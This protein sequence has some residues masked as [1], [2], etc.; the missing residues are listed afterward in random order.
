MN[1]KNKILVIEDQEDIRSTLVEMLTEE[2][3]YM[4][5]A[6]NGRLGINI[7]ISE[8]PD[9]IICD[10]AMPE[11]NGYEVLNYVRDNSFTEAIP[12]IFLTAKVSQVDVRQGMELG[13]DDYLTKPFTRA[14]LL[15]AI[16]TRLEK[17]KSFD[18][19]TQRKINDLCINISHSLPHELYT[20]LNG[21]I[22]LSR[23]LRDNFD[24]TDKEEG[25]M[26]LDEILISGQ[27]L[28][29][30]TQKF[31]LYAQLELIVSSPERISDF[32]S[33]S[34]K[35]RTKNT[36]INIAIE[37]SQALARESD[38]LTDIEDVEVKI[39]ISKLQTIV[40]EVIDNAFKFSLDSS[41][42]YVIG[43]IQDNMFKLTVVNNGRGMAREHIEKLG[44][45]MQFERK[46]YEQQGSGLGLVIAK[47]LTEL[48]GGKLTIDSI[49]NKETKVHIHLPLAK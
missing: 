44:A 35:S 12:F 11:V 17:K 15:G 28:Y 13:A 24:S 1:M 37:K 46:L 20:P 10:V 16:S 4:L 18:R 33:H 47:L 22:G 32:C 31:L 9:L 38:L 36:I 40:E 6:E 8:I 23:L 39:E 29:S 21:I 41:N 26:M 42:V 25:I 19:Q 3:Y 5:E 14:E 48:H 43:D 45:Y 49:P 30:L 7:V 34:S 2:G 27:R